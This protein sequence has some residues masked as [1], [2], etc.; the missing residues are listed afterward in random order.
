MNGFNAS[1]GRVEVCNNNQWGTVCDDFWG[2]ADASVACRQA[3]FSAQGLI[4]IYNNFVLNNYSIYICVTCDYTG[5]IAVLYAFFGHGAGPIVL[6]DVAC[7]GI[8]QRLWDC[9]HIGVGVHNCRHSED[10]GVRCQPNT[11]SMY[12]LLFKCT[13]NTVSKY[14]YD[15]SNNI[16]YR[17]NDDFSCV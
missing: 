1:E 6:D 14:A 7:T 12:P 2:A 8:E 13:I 11:T 16:S 15:S 17:M 10:A 3:G 4:E 9:S 5:A